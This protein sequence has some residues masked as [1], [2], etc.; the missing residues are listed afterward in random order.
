MYFNINR[1]L[2]MPV[3]V[4]LKLIPKVQPRR[5]CLTRT[6][7]APIQIITIRKEQPRPDLVVE[8]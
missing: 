7:H 1:L 8:K 4:P 3:T 6:C 2:P 5:L